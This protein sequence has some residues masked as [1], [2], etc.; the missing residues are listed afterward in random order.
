MEVGMRSLYES[1]L[2]KTNVGCESIFNKAMEE[3]E[4]KGKRLEIDVSFD[5]FM[6]RVNYEDFKKICEFQLNAVR[7]ER[8][9]RGTY[10][11]VIDRFVNIVLKDG[12]IAFRFSKDRNFIS[13]RPLYVPKP[14][15]TYWTCPEAFDVGISSWG[16]PKTYSPD[17]QMKFW[18][19]IFKEKQ[20]DLKKSYTEV[21]SRS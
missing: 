21:K 3:Y 16:Q 1:I 19:G 5:Y 6:H 4:G 8:P 15:I 12:V 18:F 14:L 20:D 7:K 10:S 17:Q 2:N 11:F 13:W 9:S